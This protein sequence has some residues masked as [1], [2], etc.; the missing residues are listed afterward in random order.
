MALDDYIQHTVLPEMEVTPYDNMDEEEIRRRIIERIANRI[1]EEQGGLGMQTGVP[2]V[3]DISGTL[4]ENASSVYVS[5]P[6]TPRITVTPDMFPMEPQ[7]D[8]TYDFPSSP[9]SRPAADTPKDT[10]YSTIPERLLAELDAATRSTRQLGAGALGSTVAFP[11][12]AAGA[13]L[14]IPSL[15]GVEAT[16]PAAD[17][18]LGKGQEARNVSNWLMGLSGESAKPQNAGE[19][20]WH[21][22]GESVVPAGKL[23][24]PLSAINAG[25]NVSYNWLTGTAEAAPKSD[26]AKAAAKTKREEAKAEKAAAKDAALDKE[27]LR[28]VN[29]IGGQATVKNGD[30]KTLGAIGLATMGMIFAPK[31]YTKFLARGGVPKL[32]SVEDAA[33]GTAAM[34]NNIDYMR[35]MDDVNAGILRTARRGGVD[36]ATMAELERT[37][38]GQTR[39]A[40]NALVDSAVATGKMD[41]PAFSYNSKVPLAELAKSDSKQVRD[42]L[43]ALDTFDDVIALKQK[44]GIAAGP[45]RVRGMTETDA[46]A[47]ITALERAE[48]ELRKIGA[49]Y[50]DIVKNTRKAQAEGEYATMTKSAQRHLNSSRPHTVPFEGKRH[51]DT[52]TERGSP[53]DQQMKHMHRALRNRMENEAIGL[54]IDNMRRAQPRSFVHITPEQRNANAKWEPNTVTMYRRGKPEYYTTDP[55]FASVLKMDPHYLTGMIGQTSWATKRVLEIGSTGALAPWFAITSALRSILIGKHASGSQHAPTY[56]GS[57]YA[58]PQ[59]LIP[60]LAHAI[61]TS[62][63]RGSA[64]WLGKTFGQSGVN[65]LATRLTTAYDNSLVAQMQHV[66]TTRASI[67]EQQNMAGGKLRA[68]IDAAD[69]TTKPFLKSYMNI[70]HAVHNAPMHNFVVRNKRGP[71]IGRMFGRKPTNVKSDYDLALDARHLTGDPRV[72]GQYYTGESKPIRMEGTNRVTH[73]LA[74]TYGAATEFGRTFVPWFNITTQGIKRVGE[75]YLENPARF[76]GKMWMYSMAPA[77]ASYLGAYSLGVGP[78]GVSYVDYM[79]NRR[80][81]YQKIMNMY[82]PI[83][84]RPAN[85]GMEVPRFHE[86]A[87]PAHMMEVALDHLMR[88]SMFAQMDDVKRAAHTFMDVA[89]IPPMLPIVN[90]GLASQGTVGPQGMFGGDAYRYRE[91]P[92]DQTGGPLP[93]NIEL[94]VRALAGGIGDVAGAGAVAFTQ[95]PDGIVNRFANAGSEMGKRVIAKAPLIRDIANVRAPMTGNNQV[96]EALFKK[97]KALN[98]LVKYFDKIEE[99]EVDTKGASAFGDKVTEKLLGSKVPSEM[100]G[101]NQPEPTNMLYKMFAERVR[102]RVKKDTPDKEDA[103]QGG[104]GYKSLWRRY[105]DATEHLR[106]LRKVNDGSFVTWQKQLADRPEQLKFLK[107]NNVDPTNLVQVRN[108]YEKTRQD[109]ARVLLFAVRAIEKEMSD[110]LGK[111]VRIEDLDPY[112]KPAPH[113]QQPLDLNMP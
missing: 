61:G 84:G 73:T 20:L 97:S 21:T 50:K 56:L 36:P 5:E 9:Y 11:A 70:L 28:V 41:S 72:S 112:A 76:T 1:R 77:A 80:S 79:M 26:E 65:A 40:A 92:F 99:G 110:A 96:T 63:E 87:G 86:M 69:A 6:E 39:A 43:H 47:T 19:K 82:I 44:P 89:A 107:D 59:Q 57:L 33:P 24:A 83:P 62:L 37:F 113:T 54:F 55:F 104:I 35:T 60:P 102:D 108:L 90:L 88:N 81:E 31:I 10:Q 49:A 94:M 52:P 100:A 101:V 51:M 85:K 111:P 66:G 8:K 15:A 30:Y 64:G 58:I 68:A 42:Y 109:T 3:T 106:S 98:D 103:T 38:Q 16:Q 23:T 13:V 17:W 18:F 7:T 32:R 78:D 67:L 29:T 91:D 4:G 105:G 74:R 22:V 2:D 75:A 93:N 27:A 53:F 95:T 45:P 71:I 12:Q 25:V 46:L 34:S 14:S 48:P